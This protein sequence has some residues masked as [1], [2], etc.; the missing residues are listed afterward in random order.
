MDLE[1]QVH[2]SLDNAVENGYDMR[3]G[4]TPEQIAEDIGDYDS[5]LQGRQPEE[6]VP[7]IRSWLERP[8]GYDPDAL[9]F[10]LSK[11]V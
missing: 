9:P 11:E 8:P 4:W 1:K 10:G 7:H 2:A 6:L 3:H 5:D